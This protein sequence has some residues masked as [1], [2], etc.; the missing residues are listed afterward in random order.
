MLFVNA[1]LYDNG[2][3]METTLHRTFVDSI[4][5]IMSLATLIKEMPSTNR[6]YYDP[7]N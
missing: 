7:I 4:I 3:G 2:I 5:R 1:Y 6:K